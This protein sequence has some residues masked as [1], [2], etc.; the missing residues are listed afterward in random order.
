MFFINC[1]KKNIKKAGKARFLKKQS[2]IRHIS[3]VTNNKKSSPWSQKAKSR[4]L[5]PICCA[6]KK[7]SSED[8]IL[9]FCCFKFD[10]SLFVSDSSEKR[11]RITFERRKGFEEKR[12]MSIM[13]KIVRIQLILYFD[14]FYYWKVSFD[15]LMDCL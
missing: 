12:L 11:N 7:N 6:K 5:L 1:K 10:P 3:M 2:V 9:F 14:L 8:R 15:H 13:P 4:I